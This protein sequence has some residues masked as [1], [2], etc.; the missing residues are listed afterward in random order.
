MIASPVRNGPGYSRIGGAFPPAE[1]VTWDTD[2]LVG[3]TPAMLRI[4]ALIDR[5]AGCDATVLIGG[6][7]GTGKELVA[8]AIHRR[9][10]RARGPMVCVN[11]SAI[12]DSLTESELFGAERGAYTG[13][14]QRQEGQIKLAQGGTLLLDE[15]GD[16][17]L[18]A[19]AKILRVVESKQVQRLGGRAEHVDVRILAATN[20]DLEQL[21]IERR[22]RE[23]LYFRL[24]VLPIRL[25]ALRER[26]QDIPLIVD[27]LIRE[28]N[29]RYE[30][31]VESLSPGALQILMEYDWP[32]N[33]R[34][35]RNV[36]EG[37][38]VV[39]RSQTISTGD[40]R[41]LHQRTTEPQPLEGLAPSHDVP[42]V[43]AESEPDQLMN[44][45]HATH[46]NKSEAAKLLHC[47]RMTVY[48]KMAKYRL[49]EKKPLSNVKSMAAAFR[50][51]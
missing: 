9:S 48:R 42:Q 31:N 49:P 20:Q 12:P 26:K 7:T 10:R 24:N 23:D 51:S 29:E 16:M 39:C 17:S 40:L 30:R 8:R 33:V 36:I 25:P 13:A 1:S 50:A 32:G 5:V 43:P 35:L 2:A 28:F 18:I 37:A 47:S 19:Q 15:I 14:V 11:C 38:I 44:A 21:I 4:K 22:F 45:L 3:E 34:E 27:R 6:E 41:R 46:W